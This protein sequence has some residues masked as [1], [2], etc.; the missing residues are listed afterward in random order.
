M[1]N[2]I[3]LLPEHGREGKKKYFVDFV[4]LSQFPSYKTGMDTEYECPFNVKR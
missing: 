4:L 3:P 2:K 1:I